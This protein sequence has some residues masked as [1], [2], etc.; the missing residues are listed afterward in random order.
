MTKISLNNNK[1]SSLQRKDEAQ[2]KADRIRFFQEELQF[3]EGQE[4][5]VL[6]D[7]QRKRLVTYHHETLKELSQ[8][9]DID[10]DHVQ[11]QMSTGMRIVSFLG[12][13][14]LSAAVFFFFYRFWGQLSTSIQV[15]ILIGIP[16][17]LTLTMEIAARFE[18]T[19]YFTSLIGL[20]AFASF[21]LN[22]SLLGVIFNITPTQNA[23]LAWGVFALIL[24]Y[25]Y[26]LRLLQVAGIFCLFG[27]LSATVGTWSGMY[28]LSFGERP[29]NFIVAGF[30]ITAISLVS[31]RS[32]PR[33]PVMYR[34]FG[35]LSVFISI[36]VLAN[37]GRTSYIM[38]PPEQV[39][40]IYQGAG[41]IVAGI[42]IWLGIRYH[43]SDAVNL[44]S[45]FFVIYLYTKLY[46][47]CWK[48]MPKYLFFL[49]IGTIAITFLIALKRLR[50]LSKEASQ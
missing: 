10:T 15:G 8:Q 9:F 37:W 16:I 41:F 19:L 14:A 7:E 12:A 29:E 46:D 31:H 17:L 33:F 18:K 22:L 25:T 34:L 48:W 44:G 27:Y 24:S 21:V 47:W 4:I 45:T 13:L 42:T 32:Y 35:M 39:E 43:H 26:G 23:F 38:I 3:L 50:A 28:W 30:C 40:N 36:L 6:S 11:K 49:I 1:D 2:Q 5:L 20:V